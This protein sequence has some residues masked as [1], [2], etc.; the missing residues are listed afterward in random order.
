MTAANKLPLEVATATFGARLPND[1][2]NAE[3][4]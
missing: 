3:R 1:A 2:P 4:T